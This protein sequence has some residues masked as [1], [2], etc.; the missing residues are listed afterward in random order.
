MSNPYICVFC[1]N[2]E[3]E[4]K[5]KQFGQELRKICKEEVM[6]VTKEQMKED[7]MEQNLNV[8]VTTTASLENC[9]LWCDHDYNTIL[10]QLKSNKFGVVTTTA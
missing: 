3:N 9:L 7:P 2:E 1:R 6:V 5:S 4:I 10:Q 8:V